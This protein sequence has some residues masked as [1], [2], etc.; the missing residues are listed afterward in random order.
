[1]IMRPILEPWAQQHVILNEACLAQICS[2]HAPSTPP[3]ALARVRRVSEPFLPTNPSLCRNTPVAKRRA[4][5]R[6]RVPAPLRSPTL[7]PQLVW[8]EGIR[9]VS[10][11]TRGRTNGST[12]RSSS[13]SPFPWTN[14]FSTFR[15]V[16]TKDRDTYVSLAKLAE[17]AERYTGEVSSAAQHVEFRSRSR[18]RY[19]GICKGSHPSLRRT[20][21]RRRAQPFVSCVQKPH[22]Q[23]PKQLADR[24]PFRRVRNHEK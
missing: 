16:A 23:P 3:S 14:G 17:Q 19:A 21:V 8:Q 1:M 12:I 22:R 11:E 15:M 4:C 13:L 20:L 5:P 24:L 9:S 6:L 18:C 10:E 2:Q 7:R